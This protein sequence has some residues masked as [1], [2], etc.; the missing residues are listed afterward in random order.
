MPI[1][2]NNLSGI[3]QCYYVA[4]STYHEGWWTSRFTK[5]LV[6][7]DESNLQSTSW[8]WIQVRIPSHFVS[9]NFRRFFM[10]SPTHLIVSPIVHSKAVHRVHQCAIVGD[11]NEPL[12]Y[13][14]SN[15]YFSKV[16]RHK[17][18]TTRNTPGMQFRTLY[19][20]SEEKQ[21]EMYTNGRTD[22]YLGGECGWRGVGG[23]LVS[24]FD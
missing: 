21:K 8:K 7:L 4:L 23:G 2:S 13:K 9:M 15:Q 12:K 19:L 24:K 17:S 1:R 18:L 5:F 20:L 6:P 16:P 10:P 11:R 22:K 3:L 14:T